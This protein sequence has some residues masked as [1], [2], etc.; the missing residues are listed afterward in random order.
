MGSTPTPTPTP[1]P[2]PDI[3]TPTPEPTPTPAPTPDGSASGSSDAATTAQADT[4][5]D[6]IVPIEESEAGQ[7]MSTALTRGLPPTSPADDSS[8]F[9]DGQ[10]VNFGFF[11]DWFSA[12]LGQDG[13]DPYS[14][15]SA[16]DNAVNPFGDYKPVTGD[17]SQYL[18]SRDTIPIGSP[19]NPGD[20]T[21]RQFQ[22]VVADENG[23]LHDQ[24]A[25]F[26]NNQYV[27]TSLYD[28]F[29]PV[30]DGPSI[31]LNRAPD[32]S[33]PPPSNTPPTTQPTSSA[34]QANV[35]TLP[36]PAA[37]SPPSL[38]AP[39]LPPLPAPSAQNA[40]Q[41]TASLPP[42]APPQPS[43]SPSPTPTSQPVAPR[44]T[45]T[46]TEQAFPTSD[47]FSWRQYEW[48]GREMMD[49]TNPLGGRI[50]AGVGFF[51]SAI[52]AG[53]ERFVIAPVLKGIGQEFEG[54]NMM[55]DDFARAINL[56]R[57]AL[58]LYLWE[59]ETPA[60]LGE[61]L[62]YLATRAEIALDRALTQAFRSGRLPLFGVSADGFGAGGVRSPGI[63]PPI[64]ATSE[65]RALPETHLPAEVT[66]PWSPQ[67]EGVLQKTEHQA[68]IDNL[69]DRV[70]LPS[71]STAPSTP[72]RL[73]GPLTPPVGGDP[74]WHRFNTAADG[75][76]T[77][78]AV[79]NPSD[80]GRPAPG[81]LPSAPGY[82][83]G[84]GYDR[85]HLGMRAMGFPN[86]PENSVTLAHEA[87]AYGPGQSRPV[88]M[89]DFERQVV[90][91][92]NDGQTVRYRV[93]AV[94]TGS[95]PNPEVV[96]IQAIGSGPNGI[97]IDTVIR[98]WTHH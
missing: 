53:V 27:G 80:L 49:R 98:N 6:K 26:V 94:T 69:L 97:N 65:A 2:S 86:T 11:D 88:S 68:R 47:S 21:Y 15:V 76:R 95:A 25:I 78:D 19:S 92:L 85:S 74:S 63:R 93:T 43:Q 46:F 52:W 77:L 41:P 40:P 29:E 72:S 58:D 20:G 10:Y 57:G 33:L 34:T 7:L 55:I 90:Q 79:L 37:P 67:L 42:P 45:P 28:H 9:A 64:P 73:P 83:P 24:Y 59:R 71:T 23:V 8:F 31:N 91:A 60:M 75:T 89:L 22:G 13:A 35:R 1:T 17:S 16:A 56:D 44:P 54:L 32:I 61:A 48:A 81:R 50:G 30:R 38:P 14:G 87:N 3:P 70:N 39:P 66:P 18:A 62:S 5:K 84:L 12:V 96:I 51:A 36:P 4:D 82:E